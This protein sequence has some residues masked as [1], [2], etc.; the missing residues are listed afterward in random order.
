MI[1]LNYNLPV[2][3]Q[4]FAHLLYKPADTQQSPKMGDF[5]CAIPSVTR[6][7]EVYWKDFVFNGNRIEQDGASI[8]NP[9]FDYKI[10]GK[11][12]QVS[13]HSYTR[14]FFF[15]G[16]TIS[17]AYFFPLVPR[18]SIAEKRWPEFS[19]WLRFFVSLA[20]TALIA[21]INKPKK[22]GHDTLI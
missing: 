15:C 4:V 6:S 18:W 9:I 14:R 19:C 2:F 21:V 7:F 12:Y 11:I 3:Q 13:L 20:L 8:S 1:F 10:T 16:E 5:A 17:K 22:P